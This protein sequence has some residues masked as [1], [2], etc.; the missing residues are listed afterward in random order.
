MASHENKD[1][2]QY[3]LEAD[4]EDYEQKD[5]TIPPPSDRFTQLMFGNRVP[6]RYR[7]QNNMEEKQV[8]VEQS[9]EINYFTL[10]EQID[11]I[12]VSIENLKPVLKELGPIVDFIKKKIK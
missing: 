9:N 10:M 2:E 6:K 11:D 5:E 7:E 1:N 4:S 12:M 3:D 8:E